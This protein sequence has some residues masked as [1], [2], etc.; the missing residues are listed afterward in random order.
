[1]KIAPITNCIPNIKFTGETEIGHDYKK[2]L[3][4]IDFDD[5]EDDDD[6]FIKKDDEDD[7][8]DESFNAVQTSQMGCVPFIAAAVAAACTLGA[9]I[10]QCIN[11]DKSS[12]NKD[13]I[14]NTIESNAIRTDTLLIKDETGDDKPDLIL[15]KKDDSK[16]VIDVNNGKIISD[17]TI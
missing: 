11:S 9:M 8:D 4:H 13:L 1:M 5:E 6:F 3:P 12:K 10:G 15:F 2:E 7:E 17:K 16:V 14:E